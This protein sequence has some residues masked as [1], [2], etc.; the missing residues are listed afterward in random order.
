[1]TPPGPIAVGSVGV[2]RLKM[3]PSARQIVTVVSEPEHWRWDGKFLWMSLGYD[4]RFEQVGAVTRIEFAVEG[5]GLGVGT[6]GRLFAAIYA[7]SLDRAIP[8]LVREL[9]N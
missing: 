3:A 9:S 5:D 7:R 8:N 4:H 2:I 6:L 1:M